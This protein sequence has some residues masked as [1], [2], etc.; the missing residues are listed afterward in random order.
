MLLW[1]LIAISKEIV[2]WI[3]S[4][5]DNKQPSMTFISIDLIFLTKNI[6]YFLTK[7][8]FIKHAEA[9]EF[10]K[11]KTLWFFGPK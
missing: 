3:K 8:S 10:N 9:L 11:I 2:S 5:E 6:F 4:L 1:S 7:S